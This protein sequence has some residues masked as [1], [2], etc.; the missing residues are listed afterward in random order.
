MVVGQFGLPLAGI[1]RVNSV[2]EAIVF[3][4]FIF[5]ENHLVF[6]PYKFDLLFLKLVK[7]V[8]IAGKGIWFVISVCINPTDSK[9]FG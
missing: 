1:G 9:L 7:K 4:D 5:F 3:G 8:L 6:C 2:G